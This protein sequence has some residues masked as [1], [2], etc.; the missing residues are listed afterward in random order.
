MASMTSR[1]LRLATTTSISTWPGP[2]SARPTDA[3]RTLPE[4]PRGADL[5]AEPIAWEEARIVGTGSACARPPEAADVSLVLPQGDLFLRHRREQLGGQRREVAL[6]EARGQVDQAATLEGSSRPITRPSPRAPT[7]RAPRTCQTLLPVPLRRSRGR[8][9]AHRSRLPRAWSRARTSPHRR[10]CEST[11][12][13]AERPSVAGASSAEIGD[14]AGAEGVQPSDRLV[15]P[16]RLGRDDGAARSSASSADASSWAIFGSPPTTS[17]SPTVGASTPSASS[18]R[19]SPAQLVEPVGDRLL[20]G[21]FE[22]LGVQAA[23]LDEQS[24]VVRDDVHVALDCPAARFEHAGVGERGR[25]VLPC[26]CTSRTL[27]GKAVT[28]ANVLEGDEEAAKMTSWNAASS[29]DRCSSYASMS[30]GSSRPS[31]ASAS[32]SP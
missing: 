5:G 13:S 16:L 23:D 22:M 28:R 9:C 4:H 12:R 29:R 24:A 8:G 27:T 19:C 20:A 2:G 32:P 1:K 3:M 31:A 11:S 17:H 14:P 15:E 6:R 10:T 30:I 7:G 18:W 26:T 25:P 21:A